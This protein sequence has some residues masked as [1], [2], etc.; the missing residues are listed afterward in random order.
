V[1]Q[2]T[3]GIMTKFNATG[4][5]KASVTGLYLNEAPRDTAYP[6]MVFFIVSGNPEF[7]MSKDDMEMVRIQFSIFDDD[8][9]SLPTAHIYKLLTNVFDAGVLSLSD[10]W[11]VIDLRRVSQNL[12]RSGDGTK[13]V[14]HYI[15]EYSIDIDAHAYVTTTASP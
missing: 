10:S 2:V 12:T 11:D 1:K 8:S 3:D 6:Y 14:W 7:A 5:L 4:A 15:V 13:E 9:S